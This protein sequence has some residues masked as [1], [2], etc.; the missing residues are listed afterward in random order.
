MLKLRPLGLLFLVLLLALLA[1]APVSAQFS[2][3]IQG[4]V[5]D[6]QQGVVAQATVRVTNTT[7]NVTREATTSVDGV[8]R[9]LSLGPGSYRIEVEKAGFLKA[10]REAV[11]VGISETARLDFALEVSGV[12]ESVTVASG[13][14]LV[15][16]EQGRVSG[17]VDCMQL[18]EMPLNGR[19]LYNL[20][21]LQPGVTG[22]GVSSTFGAGGG[23][24]NDSFSGESAPRINASGQR[25]EANSFTVD[26]TS[27]NGVARG[28]ITN[29]TP[30]LRIGRGSARGR[31]QL[32]G[33]G[34][35]RTA[36]R[37]SRSSPKAARTS[38]GERV[39]S[40]PERRALGAQRLRDGGPR[41][42]EEPVRLHVRRP[43]LRNRLFFFTSYE[44]L[45]QSGGR[46]SSFTVETPS[47]AT[48]SPRH[49]PT[50]SRP[51]C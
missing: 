1:A 7:T 41:L 38:S 30:Q 14:P 25:D 22:K 34:R 20:I 32:L 39:A 17:R 33:G 10:Q 9:V 21:A 45:R 19:N 4:T 15:E 8:Y 49:V 28:G 50:A 44:G 42:Q 12:Q 27:T 26:D 3:A 37:R 35:A 13:A 36:A 23:S 6:S 2:S 29:L 43:D 24:G 5:T 40:F 46:G 48:S 47:S 31:E 16:T 51:G 11:T 18:Q